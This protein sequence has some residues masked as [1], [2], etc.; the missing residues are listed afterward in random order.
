MIIKAFTLSTVSF[1]GL[2]QNISK[3][4]YPCLFS[5][6]IFHQFQKRFL[7]TENLKDNLNDEEMDLGWIYPVS[8]FAEG[9][10]SG[11]WDLSVVCFSFPMFA[12]KRET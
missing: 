9:H 10:Q 5:S 7:G 11:W 2:P 12:N 4:T 8:I 1:E 3:S 6:Y